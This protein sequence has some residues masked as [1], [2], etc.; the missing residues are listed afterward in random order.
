[1][2]EGGGEGRGKEKKEVRGD[3][4]D[5]VILKGYSVGALSQ[6]CWEG[7]K[8][9]KGGKGGTARVLGLERKGAP[10]TG[11]ADTSAP[12]SAAREGEGKGN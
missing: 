3:L 2:R 4:F 8:K 12:R 10:I 5:N 1:M 9:K 11:L 7:K 6:P